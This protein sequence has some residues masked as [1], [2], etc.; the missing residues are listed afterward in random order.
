MGVTVHFKGKLR[1]SDAVEDIGQQAQQLAFELG[2]TSNSI[3]EQNVT[4]LRVR[5]NEEP[6]DYVGAVRGFR[7]PLH[8]DAEP[9]L[10]EFDD[11]LYVQEYAKTQFAPI[12]VHIKLVEF[13]RKIQP[14]FTEL[15][16]NDE[17]EYWETNDAAILVEHM[18]NCSRVI[19]EMKQEDSNVYGPVWS[20]GRIIDLVRK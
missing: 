2:T 19:E 10:L 7:V 17:G 8:E 16:V 5:D 14:Y 12:T 15:I 11:E 20:D 18:Q 6:W 13:L 9:L 3:N 1:S 4:R